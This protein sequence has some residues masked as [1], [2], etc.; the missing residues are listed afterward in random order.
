GTPTASSNPSSSGGLSLSLSN[1]ATDFRQG[2]D[3]KLQQTGNEFTNIA[4]SFTNDASNIATN[5][6]NLIT[7][8]IKGV[9]ALNTTPFSGTNADSAKSSSS[10]E[11]KVDLT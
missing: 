8:P 10:T 2:L 7:T 9:S 1:A 5:A 11:Q 6:S 3:Q 4:N